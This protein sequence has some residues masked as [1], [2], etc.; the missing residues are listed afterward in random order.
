[1]RFGFLFSDLFWGVFLIVFGL[2]II[3]RMVFHINI[4]LFRLAIAFLLIYAGFSM[5]MCSN[6]V[7]RGHQ[8]LHFNETQQKITQP[9][10]DFNTLFSRTTI[11]L[12]NANFP[13]GKATINTVF[14]S[15]ILVIGADQPIK[16]HINSAFAGAKIPDGNTITLG[17]YTYKSPKIKEGQPF[18]EV[19]ANVI[20][21]ELQIISK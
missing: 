13:D 9:H 16:I 2:A 1:M 17:N 19:E 6:G 14:G 10:E 18:L 20:F 21:G 8:N 3:I 7:K 4:P 5:L 15:S 12:S 11:D